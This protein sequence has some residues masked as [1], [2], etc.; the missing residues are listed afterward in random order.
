MPVTGS[1]L[2]AML[3]RESKKSQ[4]D[5]IQRY[6]D[7]G[8]LTTEV[9]SQQAL[10]LGNQAG[11]SDETSV[12]SKEGDADE[13]SDDGLVLPLPEGIGRKRSS[14]RI[15]RPSKRLKEFETY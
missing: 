8:R 12:A 10:F 5:E 15:C 7:S 3:D 11:D 4:G 9:H 1:R 2:S 6:L 14:R 13:E